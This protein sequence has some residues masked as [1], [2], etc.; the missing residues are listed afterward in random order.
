MLY[1]IN[2]YYNKTLLYLVLILSE[3]QEVS[4]KIPRGVYEKKCLWI[5]M[6]F[7]HI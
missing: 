2:M 7:S 1:Y 3:S 4:T 5:Y 6:Q